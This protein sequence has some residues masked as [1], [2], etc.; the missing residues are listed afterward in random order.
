MLDPELLRMAAGPLPWHAGHL[1]ARLATGLPQALLLQG[2]LGDGLEHACLHLA[3]Q[4]LARGGPEQEEL[5]RAGT[6]PDLHYITQAPSSTKR[7][8]YDIVIDQVRALARDASLTP[9]TAA[10][11]ACVIVP[12]CHLN[13]SAADALLKLL[14]EPHGSLRFIL[15]CES[16]GRL[17]ATIRSRC[18]QGILPRPTGAEASAW[19]EQQGLESD[20]EL[21]ELGD[22][23]PLL[24][25]EYYKAQA[26][27]G[28]GGDFRTAATKRHSMLRKAHGKLA[29]LCAG[30]QVEVQELTTKDGVEPAM[31]LGWAQQWAAAGMRLSMGLAADSAQ[32]ERIFQASKRGRDPLDW[33]NLQ[34][35]L[36]DLRKLMRHELNRQLLLDRVGAAFRMLGYA[37]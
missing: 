35:E 25:W 6:H 28:K 32:A 10:V 24:A 31:W 15:G 19:I 36:T 23:A 16:R 1:R 9:V 18:V 7:L 34:Q 26:V 8:R 4:E 17:P 22:N 30:K 33:I 5:L 3:Q 20:P 27:S 11:R 14:E 21:L 12:A 2:R 13:R 29:Q 37:R